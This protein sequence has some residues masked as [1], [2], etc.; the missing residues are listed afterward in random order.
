MIHNIPEGVILV[1]PLLTAGLPLIKVIALIVCLTIPTTIGAFSSVKDIIGVE[2]V[3]QVVFLGIRIGMLLSV[4]LK[5]MIIPYI[6]EGRSSI[7][8]YI[9]LLLGFLL[10]YLVF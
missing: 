3:L 5:E 8:S 7:L 1:S 9:T 4:A 2:T 10:I 6:K